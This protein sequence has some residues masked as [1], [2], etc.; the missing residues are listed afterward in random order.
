MLAEQLQNDFYGGGGGQPRPGAIP[1]F[2]PMQQNV[3][4]RGNPVR[5]A[6]PQRIQ[7]LIGGDD[8]DMDDMDEGVHHNP[9][10]SRT[11]VDMNA[12]TSEADMERAIAAS[13]Q[14]QQ[15]QYQG[16]DEED[17]LA[18]ILEQSKHVR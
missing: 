6:E 15:N 16:M 8:D 14:Q 5:A 3:N 9:W 18:M 4:A 7:Q 17:E 10:L 13:L 2:V 1:S 12:T 11:N